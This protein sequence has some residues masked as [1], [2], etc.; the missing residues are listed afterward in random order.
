MYACGVRVFVGQAR[1]RTRLSGSVACNNIQLYYY[2]PR[3]PT[4]AYMRLVVVVV[5][6]VAV[7]MIPWSANSQMA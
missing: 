7:M 3:T 2:L 6:V 4:H 1:A 5:V